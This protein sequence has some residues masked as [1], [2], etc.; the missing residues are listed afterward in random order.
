MLVVT[1]RENDIIKVGES[2]IFI[3]K[4]RGKAMTI[5][6]NAGKEIKIERFDQ[7][8]NKKGKKSK[9]GKEQESLESRKSHDFNE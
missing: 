4:I 3:Q 6:I 1:A 5:G 8:G 7:Y 9:D 2:Y